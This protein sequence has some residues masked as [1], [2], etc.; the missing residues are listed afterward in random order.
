MEKKTQ[1]VSD[2]NQKSKARKDSRGNKMKKKN[3]SKKKE[4]KRYVTEIC[5]YVTH[6]E[7][8]W[9]KEKAKEYNSI[10]NFIR[11]NLGLTQNS[12]GRKRKHTIS[13]IDLDG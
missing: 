3:K 1:K 10:S 4:Q 6:E 9:L 8:A 13:A 7:K 2:K 5:V 11:H 12:V